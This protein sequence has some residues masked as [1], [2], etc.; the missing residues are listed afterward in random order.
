M[1]LIFIYIG[2]IQFD[3]EMWRLRLTLSTFESVSKKNIGK[4][5]I[6]FWIDSDLLF[7]AFWEFLAFLARKNSLLFLSVFPFF[8]EEDKNV[9]N[10][11]HGL[12]FFFLFSFI[13]PRE[14]LI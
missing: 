8:L 6:F 4:N 13:L 3:G 9:T 7:L 5:G 11:Q 12:V 2:K 1:V 10:V 14:G